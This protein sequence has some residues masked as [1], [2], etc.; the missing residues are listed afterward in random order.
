MAVGYGKNCRSVGVRVVWPL[1][2]TIADTTARE[3]L[4]ARPTRRLFAA[5]YII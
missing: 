1:A 3:A 5:A 2:S 4:A